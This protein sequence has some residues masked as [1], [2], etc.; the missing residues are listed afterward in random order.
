M[1][2]PSLWAYRVANI[3]MLV[4]DSIT[5]DNFHISPGR[6]IAFSF[7]AGGHWYGA[8]EN[9]RSLFPASSLYANIAAINAVDPDYIFVL[10]DAVRNADDPV[11]V[12]AFG[13]LC[14]SFKARTQ[15]IPGNHDYLSR[16]SYNT[17]LGEQYPYR[18]VAGNLLIFLDT[19]SLVHGGGKAML[20]QLAQIPTDS[21]T[22]KNVFVFSH[23]LLWALTEPGFMDMDDF[24]N[25]PFAPK[26]NADTVR[27]V[28]DKVLELVGQRKMHWF[29]G[30]VGASW[31][32]SV[33]IDH[34]Q[35]RN[36]HFYAAGLGDSETDA[37]WQ[38]EV[39]ADG[40]V[41]PQL[42][43]LGGTKDH[44]LDYYNFWH[45]QDRM[46]ARRYNERLGWDERIFAVLGSGKFWI[47]ALSGL[48]IAFGVFFWWRRILTREQN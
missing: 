6:G 13:E 2:S 47:G 20:R 29:S 10:G 32:E 48:A 12:A 28:Y 37:L 22:G 40:N 1:F 45:W 4:R 43:R 14:A 5:A 19:E 7:I 27:M 33:F 8:H 26:V 35:D 16:G 36:R 9:S 25:E 11:Q 34:S 3:Q 41:F 46:E 18:V 23:H 39:Y 31:S 21:L 17:Q 15:L 30:D 24:A 44:E 38:V 42:L